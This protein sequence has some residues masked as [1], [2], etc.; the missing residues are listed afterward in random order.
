MLQA[1][2]YGGIMQDLPFAGAQYLTCPLLEFFP[3]PLHLV[4]A[5]AGKEAADGVSKWPGLERL[6][7]AACVK[8][9]SGSLVHSRHLSLILSLACLLCPEST[10]GKP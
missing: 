6:G 2:L 4:S 7:T 10:E 8:L 3:H 9:P 1:P 5:V